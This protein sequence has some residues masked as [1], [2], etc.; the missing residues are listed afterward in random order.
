MRS[1]GQVRD[2]QPEVLVIGAGPSGLFVAAELAR[3]GVPSRVVERWPTPHHEAR[4]TAIQSGTLE[5][6]TRAEV[7]APVLEAS[8][9]LQFARVFDTD[10]QPLSELAYSGTG[11]RFEFQCSLPQWRTERILAER[12]VELGGVV[13]RGIAAASLEPREDGVLVRL[14]RGDGTVEAVEVGW[15]IGAGGAHS[16]TRASLSEELVG[17]TYAGTALAADV[18]MSGGPPRDGSNLI[19]TAR[20]TSCSVH[21]PTSAG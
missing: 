16:L 5:I 12:L 3:H 18:R 20:G 10:L 19:A 4:A 8:L 9:H 7:V 11:C 13:E 17:D 15:V 6:L 21:C 1:N 2:G 14:E